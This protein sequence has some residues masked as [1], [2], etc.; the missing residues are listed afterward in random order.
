[1]QCQNV[2]VSCFRGAPPSNY[3]SGAKKGG[4]SISVFVHICGGGGEKERKG[5]R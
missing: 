1:M 3:V 2:L 4:R 5:D